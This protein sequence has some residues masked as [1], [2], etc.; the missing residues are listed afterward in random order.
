MYNSVINDQISKCYIY[1]LT[2]DSNQYLTK[3][4]IVFSAVDWLHGFNPFL[5]VNIID[6][7]LQTR[8]TNDIF[9][10]MIYKIMQICD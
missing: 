5:S 1:Y 3:M 8:L 7:A 6:I 4:K 2:V 9:V 10:L